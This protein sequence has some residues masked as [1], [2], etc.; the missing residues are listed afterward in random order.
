MT[1]ILST[2][3]MDCSQLLPWIT[4]I[5][6][7]FN[8]KMD[9]SQLLSWII[10]I[11]CFLSMASLVYLTIYLVLQIF[12]HKLIIF[13][14]SKKLFKPILINLV[15]Q[16]SWHCDPTTGFSP[17]WHLRNECRNSILMMCRC[18]DLGRAFD[19]LKNCFLL[20]KALSRSGKWFVISMQLNM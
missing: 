7:F 2:F 3:K 20:S 1:Y 17:K 15:W 4:T 9:C 6:C 13:Y 11:Y 18:P 5:Y 19:W 16:N 8:C 12:Y 14:L 10:T